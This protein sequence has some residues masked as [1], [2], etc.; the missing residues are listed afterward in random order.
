VTELK[1][2]I[3]KNTFKKLEALEKLSYY[4]KI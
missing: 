2:I 1:N 4:K 3:E